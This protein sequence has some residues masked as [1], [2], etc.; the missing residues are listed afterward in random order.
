MKRAMLLSLL[1]VGYFLS[2]KNFDQIPLFSLGT[3]AY[4]QQ[5]RIK[6]R[7]PVVNEG[8]R[9][10]LTTIDASGSSISGGVVWQSGSPDIA[11]VNANTGEVFGVKSG[12][13]TITAKRG[14]ETSSVFIVVAKVRK[15]NGAKVPGD[16]KLDS[17]GSIYISNPLQNVIL[18]AN[19]SLNSP[20]QVYAG[21]TKVAGNKNGKVEEALFAGPTAIGVN[22]NAN[23]GLYVAD[24][25]N[26]SI[27]KVGFNKQVET[28]I[29]S[30][31]PG[32]SLFPSEGL[33]LS[34]VRLS[35][36]RG[37]VSDAGGNFY[38]AD[39]DNHA[40]YY[41][42]M[43]R[44]RVFLLAGEPGQ[45]GKDD[46]I[47]RQ[48]KFRRPSGMALSSD[49]RLLTVADE[50]NNRV[51]LIDISR[52]SQGNLT[53]TVST[54]GAA[55]IT[56]SLASE[57]SNASAEEFVFDKP[58]SVGL[59]GLGNIYVVDR[60]GVQLITRSQRQA[61]QVMPLAQQEVSF[62]SAVSLTI[63]GTEV[64]VLDNG[65][66]DSE[67]LKIV[68]VG[69]PKINS[70]EP[71][72]INLGE[73]K[74]IVVKGSSFAPESQVIV[75]GKLVQ[76]VKVVSAE[77]IRFRFPAKNAPG[78]LTLTVLTRGGIAQLPLDVIA[79]PASMLNAGEITTIAGG[80]SFNGDGGSPDQSSFLFVSK[81]AIDGSGNLFIADSLRVRRIDA[82]TKLITTIAGDG[83]SF[84]DDV[85]AG[86]AKILARSL[87]VDKSG[88]LFV[89]DGFTQRIRRIDSIT[90]TITTVAGKGR[91]FSGDGGPAINAGFEEI[92]DLAFDIN[93]NLLVLEQKRLRHIDANGII[94][95]IAGNGT[96]RFS[97]DGG[98]AINAGLGFAGAIDVDKKGNIFI[99]ELLSGR[100]RR[101]DTSG[102]IRT[103]AG[104]GKRLGITRDGELSIKKDR[105]GRPATKVSLSS[106]DAITISDNT[107]FFIDRNK[108]V[109]FPDGGAFLAA[110]IS[111][112]DLTTGLIH[113]QKIKLSNFNTM[114]ED[115][116]VSG[117]L[118]LDGLG[119]LF[120]SGNGFIYNLNPNTGDARLLAGS[121][122]FNFTPDGKPAQITSLGS[123]L[124]AVFDSNDNLYIADFANFMVRKIDANTSIVTTIVGKDT[125]GTIGNGDGGDAAK[126]IVRP[127]KLAIDSQNNLI[128]IDNRAL[129]SQIRKV[130]L[131]TNIITTIGGNGTNTDTGD[132]GPAIRAG[133]SP[134]FSLALDPNDNIF[135]VTR[136]SKLRKIDSK[137]GIITTVAKVAGNS[138]STSLVFDKSGRILVCDATSFI[139]SIDPKTGEV[140]AFAGDGKIEIS[141]DGGPLSQASLGVV[142]GLNIDKAGNLFI[143]SEKISFGEENF[144]IV[145]RKV[146]AQTKI[147]NTIAGNKNPALGDRDYK[148]DGDIATKANLGIVNTVLTDKKGDLYLVISETLFNS[149]RLV[150]LSQ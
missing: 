91:K 54:L 69:G 35:S 129:G 119:N 141:G 32:V 83:E 14:S 49:G 81:T 93:N 71:P 106:P 112:I 121:K 30:G 100:I 99:T 116:S 97:G 31:S 4:Q 144:V 90:N 105:E 101:I 142:I 120:F 102:I 134:T 77:E 58:Q 39:T 123:S 104:N 52:D 126:A 138:F 25:L 80:R 7:N 50:D 53:G 40:V 75:S 17:N 18:K 9:I 98:P 79:K 3:K 103:I 29:G 109:K 108:L 125:S 147:I 65:G 139:K 135:F 55:S 148:G 22:N 130:N 44:G 118:A 113:S 47:G 85:L 12:F 20:L 66:L 88:N 128:I 59:D 16:T 26:H 62:N 6:Q 51:R 60:I 21:T 68:S 89:A 137:T 78:K 11:Q 15:S 149:V 28:L 1:L 131:K 63:K 61:P 95:T 143:V 36:P 57:T 140:T 34:N 117:K 72:I 2:P 45:S 127:I 33:S 136:G 48:A 56:Q 94:R 82:Q 41:A 124:D 84:E 92:I 76:D 132:D 150:K 86:T 70:V 111:K 145:V 10:I 43:S 107:L 24:T 110:T 114:P 67:S 96:D 23:G 115:F 87:A 146:D 8:N 73:N 5:I 122:K 13:A 74:E 46:G 38:I 133:I 19:N 37:V 64:F 27:R 42:D